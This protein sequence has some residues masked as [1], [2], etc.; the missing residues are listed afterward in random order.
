MP[1]AQ[2]K[3][4]PRTRSFGTFAPKGQP[5]PHDDASLATAT[6]GLTVVERRILGR[7]FQHPL[8]HNLSWY[9]V[10]ELFRAV[11][12]V[13]RAHNGNLVLKLGTAHLTFE[14]AQSKTLEAGDV[15]ALRNFLKRAGWTPDGAPGATMASGAGDDLVIV[16]DRA[17]A[18]VYPVGTEGDQTPH[19]QHHLHHFID[20]TQ[21]D[22]DREETYP[23]DTRYFDTIAK[24]VA[25][26]GRIVVIGH[27]KGQSNEAGHLMAYLGA[28]HSAVHA[29]VACNIVADL[30]HVTVPQLLR[31]ARDALKSATAIAMPATT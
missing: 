29:R 22:A 5:M 12:M 21:N 28:H 10:G 15:M 23:A 3:G 30:P 27:G 6:S 18:R 25:G 1:L 20:P 2:V 8:S 17:G 31:L 11:G 9:E 26:K 24:A 19:E 4:Q 7:I 13:D 16:I 14:P